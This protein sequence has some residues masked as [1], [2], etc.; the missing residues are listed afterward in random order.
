MANRKYLILMADIIGSGESSGKILMKDFK[1]LVQ[2][3]S[4]DSKNDFLSPI[5]I[6][7]GDEFQ[8]LLKSLPKAIETLFQL[9]EERLKLKL[10]WRLRYVL[11]LGKIDTP[12]NREIAHEMVGPGLTRA[13]S[14][15]QELKNEDH[16]FCL[17][18]SGKESEWLNDLFFLYQSIIDKWK[19]DDWELA[20]SF[21]QFKDYKVVAEKRKKDR[22]HMWR[23]ERSLEMP[24]YF[25]IKKLIKS[26]VSE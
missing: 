26:I 14:L 2:K 16:R 22:A 6:T 24:Q 18:L 17:E 9:E 13:R 3:V 4:S 5:T 8:A 12:I 23:R 10:E 20:Y 15:L 7:L 21:I 25:T 11:H 1:N 19:K